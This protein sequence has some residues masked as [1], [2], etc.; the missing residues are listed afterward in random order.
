ME[1]DTQMSLGLD[2]GP[3][4]WA[5]TVG[6]RVQKEG[7]VTAE[8]PGLTDPRDSMKAKQNCTKQ[9]I[10]LLKPYSTH[11]SETRVEGRHKDK[12]HTD[13]QD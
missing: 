9:T 12:F 4:S 2:T 5:E 13:G 8:K 1:E 3:R 6:L 10:T 11:K 7:T